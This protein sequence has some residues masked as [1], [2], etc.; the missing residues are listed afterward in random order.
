MAYWI[1]SNICDSYL[2]LEY[3]F[4]NLRSERYVV[5]HQL[6]LILMHCCTLPDK[7]CLSQD[8]CLY[9]VMMTLHF[10]N[11]LAHDAESTQTSKI[12]S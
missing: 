2:R 12:L 7:L 5:F 11:D 1:T 8:M 10:L 4:L 9:Q 6:S 3:S